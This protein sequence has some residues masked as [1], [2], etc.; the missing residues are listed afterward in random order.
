[1]PKPTKK[2]TLEVKQESDSILSDANL[3]SAMSYF[4]YFIGAAAMYF[5]AED[6]RV[7]HHAKYSAMMAAAVIVL[8]FVLN[9][10]F[11]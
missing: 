4:P 11:A 6:K 5:L 1:M 3:T 9:G 2:V 7:M 10:F 8:M